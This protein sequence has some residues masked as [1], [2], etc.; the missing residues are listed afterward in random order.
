MSAL[1]TFPSIAVPFICLQKGA[2][3]FLVFIAQVPHKD[4]LV[5]PEQQKPHDSQSQCDK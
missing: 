3:D 4:A 5:V 2:G 1:D